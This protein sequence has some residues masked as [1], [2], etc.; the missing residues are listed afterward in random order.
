MEIRTNIHIVSDLLK[1]VIEHEWSDKFNITR[2]SCCPS[3][4]HDCCPQCGNFKN[5]PD[6]TRYRREQPQDGIHT[7][8]CSLYNL[9]KEARAVIEAENEIRWKNDEELIDTY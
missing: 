1:Y 9:I 6:D 8:G 5:V 2:C 3:E 7:N 4:Y